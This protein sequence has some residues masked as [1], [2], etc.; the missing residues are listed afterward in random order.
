MD[1]WTPMAELVRIQKA[2][3]DAGVASRR[4][5]EELVAAGR[6]SVN[7]APAV[8][9]QRVDLDADRISVDGHPLRGAPQRVWLVLHKPAGVTSTVSD[10]HAATTVLDL[11]PR[12][13]RRSAARL[14]PVGRLDQD[15]EGLLLLTNDGDWA[16]RVLHPRYEVER[17]YA[18]GVRFPLDGEQ[19][20]RL[21]AG[22]PLDEGL[23]TLGGL[24][25]ASGVETQKLETLAGRSRHR[26]VWY[27]AI[28]TQGWKRQIRRMFTAVDAPV[29][30]LVRVRIG[31]LRLDG[32][33][34]GQ[35]RHLSAAERDRL[36][37]DAGGA[38]DAA[39]R[40]A[41][42]QPQARRQVIV[43]IDGPGSSGK[44][45]VGAAAAAAVGYRFCDTGVLYR[46]LAWLAAERGV[47][48]SDGPALVALIP[49]MQLA[50]DEAGRLA[51]VLV[52]GRDITLQLHEAR[53]DRVVSAVA[54][55]PDV[56]AALLPVQRR[57]AEGGGI[58]M[59]GRDIGSVVLPDADLRLYLQ[60]SL[61]V[62]AAR[63]AAQRG[64]RPDSAEGQAI[65]ADLRRRDGLDSSRETAPL[66][67]PEGA[68]IIDA[69]AL[70]FDRTV[71]AVIAAIRATER[72]AA[73]ASRIERRS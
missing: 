37:R 18:I 48:P 73:R 23:A 55:D 53:V 25:P 26:L 6:V 45:S 66:R 21:R 29:E 27:R 63:R 65:L 54:A 52:E 22:I 4:A 44:S 16:Q 28:L 72:Q 42:A 39:V 12:E 40:Q 62:R 47:D 60:V 14:Y 9:G 13:V 3:A 19:V 36:A 33:S 38:Q 32:L 49:G 43:S 17:E 50:P 20:E 15:S 70:T 2:L 24:R 34:T 35:L 57:I 67:I 10:R 7:G 11:V 46:G 68:V 69:D 59:A 71:A 64:L 31:T 56:R 5:A 30:R 41:G 1:R 61:E 51:R 8:I 58:V